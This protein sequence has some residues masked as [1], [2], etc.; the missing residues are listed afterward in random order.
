MPI[1]RML[2]G[3]NFSPESAAI[4]VAELGLRSQPER[5]QAAKV[6]IGTCGS[7]KRSLTQQGSATRAPV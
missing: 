4:L 1:K 6:I 5:E 7:A 2:A 3:R